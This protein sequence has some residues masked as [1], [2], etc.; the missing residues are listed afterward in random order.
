[1]ESYKALLP[2]F[3][4]LPTYYHRVFLGMGG[5]TPGVPMD[6]RIAPLEAAVDLASGNDLAVA[7]RKELAA[8]AGLQAADAAKLLTRKEIS[9]T[10]NRAAAS[11]EMVTLAPL[12]AMLELKDNNYTMMAMGVLRAFAKDARYRQF[13]V[14]KSRASSG[15]LKERLEYVLAN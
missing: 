6:N 10:A 11:G 5:L 14:D 7:W 1:M 4:V 2:S 13:F 3:K 9:D 8:A 12:V 15:R